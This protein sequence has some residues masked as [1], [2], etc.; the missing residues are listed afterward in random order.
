MRKYIK[1]K[2]VQFFCIT[3][4]FSTIKKRLLKP[5][6]TILFVAILYNTHIIAIA[7][8]NAIEEV[9]LIENGSRLIL[10]S[11]GSCRLNNADRISLMQ[12]NN[13]W[14][15]IANKPFIERLSGLAILEEVKQQIRR[16]RILMPADSEHHTQLNIKHTNKTQKI[17]LYSVDMM[18]STYPDAELLGYFMELVSNI[19][20]AESYCQ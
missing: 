3:I 8:S 11:D 18:H 19:R 12:E 17:S 20:A 1:R 5:K 6:V 2:F 7:K 13:N 14:E 9:M 4:T 16:T 10:Y 15:I